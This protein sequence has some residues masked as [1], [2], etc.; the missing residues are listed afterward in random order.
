MRTVFTRSLEVFAL[1]A[2]LCFFYM[3]YT[4]HR[5]LTMAPDQRMTVNAIEIPDSRFQISKLA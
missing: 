2:I 1:V 5:S 3:I 4:D